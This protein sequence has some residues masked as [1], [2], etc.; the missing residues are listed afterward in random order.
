MIFLLFN[1]YETVKRWQRS[2]ASEGVVPSFWNGVAKQEKATSSFATLDH[3]KL[4]AQ[5][6][7]SQNYDC[8]KA[9]LRPCCQKASETEFKAR[10]IEQGYFLQREGR[11]ARMDYKL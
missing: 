10:R 4:A 5:A 11:G 2:D 8:S 6:A 3:S 7:I 9:V 1:F